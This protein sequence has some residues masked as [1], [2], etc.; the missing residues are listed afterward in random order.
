MKSE[1]L[2]G[3]HGCDDNT[4]VSMQLEEGEYELIESLCNLVT[5]ANDNGSM[6]TMSIR[7]VELTH[8]YL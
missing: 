7:K 3:C 2:I 8:D 4:Y 1:Y 5:N 6:P